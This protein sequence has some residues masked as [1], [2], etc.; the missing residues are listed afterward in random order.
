MSDQI[1]PIYEYGPYFYEM[2]MM[3]ADCYGCYGP[4]R[5]SGQ[6]VRVI[7]GALVLFYGELREKLLGNERVCHQ[8]SRERD[9]RAS[10]KGYS[11]D[12]YYSGQITCRS[13]DGGEELCTGE[14]VKC[15]KA[16]DEDYE[17]RQVDPETITTDSSCYTRPLTRY[18]NS[19]SMQVVDLSGPR[20]QLVDPIVMPAEEEGVTVIAGAKSVYYSYKTPVDLPDDPRP[21]VRYYFKEI[22]LNTPSAPAVGDPVNIPGELLMMEGSTLFTQDLVWGQSIAETA[23]NKL[24]LRDGLA[25]RQAVYRFSDRIVDAV[26]LDGSSRVLVSHQP[27]WYYYNYNNEDRMSVLTLLYSEDLEELAEI[28]VDSWATLHGVQQN[29][30]LFEVPGGLLIINVTNPSAPFPQA[31]FPT[32]GWPQEILFEG[33][34][35]MFAAGRYGV[36]RFA[37]DSFNLLSP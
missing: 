30:A 18:W 13:L 33:D 22:D 1:K 31:Y 14:I 20:P 36:Y 17:C 11:C 24:E 5:P 37:A 9:C 35:I 23:V 2:D 15:A 12:E 19:Y 34:N 10:S 27:T 8:Y 6:N 4:S 28:E 25:Y 26:A 32:R 21:F 7:D 3:F 29:R 16:N